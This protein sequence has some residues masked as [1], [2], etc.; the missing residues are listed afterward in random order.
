MTVQSAGR[1]GISARVCIGLS[2]TPATVPGQLS[3]PDAAN[4]KHASKSRT[5]RSLGI[6]G[7]ADTRARQ[8]ALAQVLNRSARLLLGLVSRWPAKG[9]RLDLWGESE[10]QF[11]S[12]NWMHGHVDRSTVTDTL[13]R[14][15]SIERGRGAATY[16]NNRA[17]DTLDRVGI[18]KM[19]YG[20]FL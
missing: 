10:S 19:I 8:R 16:K 7:R 13:W 3:L 5:A 15:G 20:Y 2:H 17:A 18:I 11:S 1:V 14:S 4:A 6:V 12:P 9:A